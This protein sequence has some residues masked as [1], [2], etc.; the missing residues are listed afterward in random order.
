[1][2]SLCSESVD[3]DVAEAAEMKYWASAN[4]FDFFV[5]S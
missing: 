3:R 4:E 1:M 5:R 2:S